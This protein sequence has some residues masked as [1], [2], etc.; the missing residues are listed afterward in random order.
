MNSKEKLE[1]ERLAGYYGDLD[2]NGEI[3]SRNITT[4]FCSQPA[5]WPR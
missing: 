1:F 5:V 2:A 4:A 3:E